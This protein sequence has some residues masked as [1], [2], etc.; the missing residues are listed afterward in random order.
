M[1]LIANSVFK[2]PNG[3]TTV[4]GIEIPYDNAK[5][6]EWISKGLAYL[7]E[8]EA[9]AIAAPEPP[10]EPDGTAEENPE[11]SSATPEQ[12]DVTVEQTDDPATKTAN[13]GISAAKKIASNGSKAVQKKP[14]AKKQVKK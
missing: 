2:L 11:N 12:S 13:K 4:P 5:A 14:A 9:A 7:V 8:S 6:S 1:K 10:L 3:N